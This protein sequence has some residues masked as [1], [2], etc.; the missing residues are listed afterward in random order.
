LPVLQDRSRNSLKQLPQSVAVADGINWG[1]RSAVLPVV[2][3][4]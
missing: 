2:F 3:V 4:Q 1:Y